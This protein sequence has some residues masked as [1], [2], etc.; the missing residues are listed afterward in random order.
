[1]T[2]TDS[3]SALVLGTW[4]VQ[5]GGVVSVQFHRTLRVPDT[6]QWPLPA[7]LGSFPMTRGTEL[8]A[9]APERW[10]DP[11]V[12]VVPMYPQEAMWLS[13]SAQEPLALQVSVGARCALTGQAHR[14]ELS[15]DPQNYLALPEQP[16]L[17]GVHAG[18]GVVSQ[19]VAVRKGSGKSVEAQ[20]TGAE[21]RGGLQ[22]TVWRLTPEARAAWE[23]EQER[24]RTL[25][26][27]DHDA[28]MPMMAAAP[29]GEMG[30]G[31]GGSIR[32]E[33]FADERTLSS[34]CDTPHATADVQLV[35]AARWPALTGQPAPSTPVTMDAYV[36]AGIPWF[37]YDAPER[38]VLP[39]AGI[40]RRLRKAGDP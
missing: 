14:E 32:Q 31:A 27:A 10:R 1:M 30:V 15:Q 13:F 28:A 19:F 25:Y 37:A 3:S 29:T 22:L 16:W 4:G 24:N 2:P 12:L 9:D 34:Y 38:R 35:D 21:D 8:L 17:D 39:G 11:G 40:L 6:G 18:E 26:N 33:V 20:L 7:G 36:R 23:R 5:L